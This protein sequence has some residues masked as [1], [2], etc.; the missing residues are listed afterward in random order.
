MLHNWYEHS[1]HRHAEAGGELGINGR[2]YKGG[3]F[4]PFYVPRAVMPQIDEVDL[5][6]FIDFL[7]A[8]EVGV[9]WRVF[10]PRDLRAHQKVDMRKVFAMSPEVLAKPLLVS[11]D[12]FVLDGNHRWTGHMH[13]GSKCNAWEI[14]LHFEP[15]IATMFEFPKTY[16]YGDGNYHPITN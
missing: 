1:F 6:E 15:A 8:K 2:C 5:P 4:M 7:K 11:A 16:S 3:T 9:E 13:R 12:R 14:G 10:D